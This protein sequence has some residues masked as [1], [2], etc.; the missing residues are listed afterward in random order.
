MPPSSAARLSLETLNI[1]SKILTLAPEDRRILVALLKWS[2]N[3]SQ[4]RMPIIW[5]DIAQINIRLGNLYARVQQVVPNFAAHRDPTREN[6]VG[7]PASFFQSAQQ[8]TI[9]GG[10]FTIFSQSTDPVAASA[11]RATLAARTPSVLDVAPP[12]QQAPTISVAAEGTQRPR[13]D[14]DGQ[15]APAV[16]DSG[17]K[18][19]FG[20]VK[21]LVMG[22]F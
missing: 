7:N 2:P 4:R 5:A 11:H 17:I 14:T 18:S 12:A 1:S 21:R 10:S 9:H 3:A 16:G 13:E 15:N 8:I 20:V 22:C 19:V 6:A